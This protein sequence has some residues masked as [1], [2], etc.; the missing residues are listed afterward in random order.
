MGKRWLAAGR[1]LWVVLA[2]NSI[3]LFLATMWIAYGM[4]QNPSE[5]IVNVLAEQGVSLLVYTAFF[6]VAPT[7]LFLVFFGVA[8]VIFLRRPDDG[9]ALFVSIFLV[10][11]GAALAYPEFA[12]FMQFYR[13]PPQWYSLSALVVGLASWTLLVPFLV[14]YPD[15][16]FV[17]P[18][19]RFVAGF[20][21]VLTTAWSFF[22]LQM[23]DPTTTLGIVGT[24]SVMFLACA[25]VV[26]QL[27]RYRRYAA[28]VERQ[29]TKW[30]LYA[31][32]IFFVSTVMRFLP[33]LNSLDRAAIDEVNIWTELIATLSTLTFLV[34]PIAVGIA[35]LRYRLWD[36]DIIIRRT[37]TYGLLT[38]L[39]IGIYFGT[40]VL[41][42]RALALFTGVQQNEIVTV[43]S[44][45][46]I[47]ALFIPLRNRIQDVIDRRFYRK[48]YDAQLVLQ[49]FSETVRDETDLDRLNA[50]LMNVVQ[51]TMQPASVSLWLKNAGKGPSRE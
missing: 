9:F 5:R 43:L 16:R 15:G 14:L 17:P 27:I 10:N 31:L 37:L 23:S 22:P 19:T 25:A 35:I 42:Q 8:L 38:A 51:E 28:P 20:A 11:Y 4:L 3:F 2:V 7:I 12:E 46:A 30:F 44:T 33:P 24:L 45:L 32:S 41:L 6:M 18:W 48:R 39:L 26:A 13:I 49:K 34:L 36:I 47:A 50:E 29:Q 1:V 40:I 21:V